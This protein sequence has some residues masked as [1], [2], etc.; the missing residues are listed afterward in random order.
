MAPSFDWKILFIDDEEGIRKVMRVTLEDAGYE[1]ATAHDG[2]NGVRL[3]KEV[4]PHIVITDV[5]MP[6]M[7][8]IQVLEAVKKLNSDIEVIVATAFG[9]IDL[10][11]RALQLDASD[12]IIKP[13]NDEILFLALNRAQERFTARKQLRDHT[14]LL[15]MGWAQTTQELI[16]TF[17]FQENLIQSSM[18][19]IIGCDENDHIVTYNRSMEHMLGY[20]KK[21][22]LSQMNL[23]Q[24]FPPGEE[25]RLK[26]KLNGPGYG[27]KNFLFLYE[28]TLLRPS[29]R[30][31]PVQLS[32]SVLF[33][34]DRKTGLV[35][36]FRDLQEIRR[37]ERE[38]ADQARILHQ[39]KMMSLGRLA[40][41]VVHEINN[42]L[43]GI[44][45]YIRLMVRV[46]GRGALAE[47]QREKFR[48][49]LDLVESETSRCSQIVSNLLTFSRKAPISFDQ[50]NV[51]DLLQ[52]SI[53]L[54]QH[55]LEL[56]NIRLEPRIEPDIPLVKGDANQLQQCIINLIFN[57][58]DA[59]AEGGSLY[60]EGSYDSKKNLVILKVS[61]TGPGIRKEDIPHLF[62]PFFTT[63]DE[64]YG[65]GLGLSTVYGIIEHHKGTVTAE[66][67]P[68]KGAIFTIQLPV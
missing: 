5:R 25:K 11:I 27:G 8:G 31:I 13:I 23:G 18:D 59:M 47:D 1:V 66:S 6:K 12:F 20:S 68:G 67:P 38:V 10:A 56:S 46:L 43:A 42:P 50:V 48:K 28:T 44:L 16:R 22:V 7:D 14:T 29:G 65:V 54:C 37:L 49:Y 52:R 4:S 24:F 26:E 41:S 19:G 2:E 32:A 33:E 57:A 30:K 21:E 64:G 62:E 39:D 17:S 36:F 63:K 34:G 35:C 58:I 45:N 40:A 9:E 15:E 51:G 53:L 60:L 3:C 55:K 61:D